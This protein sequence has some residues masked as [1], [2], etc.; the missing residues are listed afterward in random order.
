MKVAAL[1]NTYVASKRSLGMRY[2][3][4]AASLNAFARSVGD[5]DIREVTADMALAFIAGKGTVTTAWQVRFNDLNGLYRFAI[6]RGLV[7]ISPL[8]AV[9]PTI[10]PSRTPYIYSTDEI[11]R[12]LSATDSLTASNDRLKAT[13][14]RMLLLLLYGSGLRISEALSLTLQ[15]VN[16]S[17]R[18]LTVRGTKF[19]KTRWVPIGPKLADELS[20]Y[21]RRRCQLRL[22]DGQGSALFVSRTGRAWGYRSVFDLFV[23][24]RRVAGI[25]REGGSRSAPCLHD[26]R[27]TAAVHRALHWYRAGEDVQRL[28]LPLATYLGH[29]ELASTQRY[30][31]MTPELLQEAG[32]REA[33]HE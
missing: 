23:R 6:C 5:T 19:F 27:H 1:V 16:L 18:V 8:P 15:D 4:Q 7:A 3:S 17:E 12:L 30:L 9:R 33:R 11:R 2:R 25:S 22:P 14:L 20:A 10:P 31:T 13:T 21:L 32:K 29:V 24:V 28:L 26:I